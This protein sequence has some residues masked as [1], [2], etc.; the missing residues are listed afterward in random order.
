MLRLGG[1]GAT[2]RGSGNDLEIVPLATL[3]TY[4]N[5]TGTAD[6]VLLQHVLDNVHF[7]VYRDT[8]SRVFKLNAAA[9]DEVYD[10]PGTQ[11]LNLQQY[12]VAVITSITYGSVTAST[13]TFTAARSYTTA[14][15][16]PVSSVG[17]LYTITNEAWPAGKH[18]LRVV[19]TAGYGSTAMP[20]DLMDAVCQWAGVKY[21]RL[22]DRRWD[23]TS[24]GREFETTQYTLNEAPTEVRRIIDSYKRLEVGIG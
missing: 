11:K 3:K 10:G 2:V 20:P 18:V 7:A 5:E 22:K 14:E 4:L 13:P 6:D 1:P 21:S 12:P 9:F 24:Q 8:G 19:Y 17:A 16:Y 23:T 15:W